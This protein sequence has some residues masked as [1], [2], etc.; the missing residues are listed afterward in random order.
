MTKR[1]DVY[2][3]DHTEKELGDF[4]YRRQQRSITQVQPLAD[5]TPE[6]V[7]KAMKFNVEGVL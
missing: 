6:E 3:V 7:E 2:A 5:V 1:K 4:L